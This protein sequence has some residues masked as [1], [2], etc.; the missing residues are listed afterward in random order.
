MQNNRVAIYWNG[1]LIGHLE[2][3]KYVDM[4]WTS[5]RWASAGHADEATLFSLLPG[6]D[7]GEDGRDV[8]YNDQW[9]ECRGNDGARWWA[10]LIL[11]PRDGVLDLR[12]GQEPS[13]EELRHQELR[14]L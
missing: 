3:H 10:L 13:E 12:V 5:G 2:D 14:S 8:D 1:G 7:A 4:W 11:P 6:H 9:V